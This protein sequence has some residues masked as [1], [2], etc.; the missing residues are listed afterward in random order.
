LNRLIIEN[1]KE[2]ALRQTMERLLRA[3]GSWF[4]A[5]LREMGHM[6]LFLL[7]ALCLAFIP[8]FKFRLLLKRIQFFGNKSLLVIMLTGSFT[9]MVLALQL[10]YIL[11]K[12]GSDALLGP[13]IALSLIREL[14]PVLTAE[15]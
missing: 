8:P 14:G 11:R 9:G 5:K 3:L 13:G 2:R 10:Y 12:F 1:L 7:N 4:I 15:R 6:F